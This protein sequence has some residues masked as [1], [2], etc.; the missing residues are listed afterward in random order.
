M[1]TK[2]EQRVV[3]NLNMAQARELR[4]YLISH[5]GTASMMKLH[6]RIDRSITKHEVLEQFANQGIVPTKEQVTKAMEV[7]DGN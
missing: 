3:L 7:A 4:N 5:G 2:K 6:T 1:E